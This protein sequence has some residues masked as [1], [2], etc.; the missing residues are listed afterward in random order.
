MKYHLMM[1]LVLCL[2]STAQASLIFLEDF[3]DSTITYHSSDPDALND[4]ANRD[5]YG[6]VNSADLHSATHYQNIQGNSFYAVQ[7]TDG[8]LPTAASTVTLS[9]SNINI[10]LWENISLS[11]FLAE[12]NSSDGFEDFDANTGFNIVAQVDN[13]GFFNLFSVRSMLGSNGS[14][15]NTAPAVDTDF[16]GIGDGQL[17]TD[18]FEAFSVAIAEGGLLDIKVSFSNFNAQDED[19]AFDHLSLVG[20]LKDVQRSGAINVPEPRTYLLMLLALAAL[21]LM[22]VRFDKQPLV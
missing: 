14:R 21:Y 2:S 17:I 18:N 15:T 8:A 22:T 9:W 1:A 12:D 11:W 13:G 7:D 5:Y 4:L 19:I 16:D 10:S 3:E 6:R 20:D